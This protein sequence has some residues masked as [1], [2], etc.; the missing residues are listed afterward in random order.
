MPTIFIVTPIA[1]QRDL[2]A[3]WLRDDY[4]VRIVPDAA[5]ALAL[6][7]RTEPDLIFLALTPSEAEGAAAQGQL[8]AQAR[9]QEIPVI[10]LTAQATPGAEAV[11]RAA[12]CVGVF[13]APFE[14]ER[15]SALL[16]TWLGGG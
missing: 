1:A 14:A 2:L 9:R 5:S 15:L 4:S 13:E 7:T 16:G 10:G 12:G 6:S 8:T 3:G 11:A